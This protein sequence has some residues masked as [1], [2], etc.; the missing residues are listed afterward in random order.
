MLSHQAP[1]KD[2]SIWK[3]L[4]RHSSF[5]IL[6]SACFERCIV[7]ILCVLPSP[8]ILCTYSNSWKIIA[9]KWNATE[10]I[11]F[12]YVMQGKRKH[13]YI[14]IY[15]YIVDEG[16]VFCWFVVHNANHWETTDGCHCMYGINRSIFIWVFKC[17]S[18]CI[19]KKRWSS[20][21]ECIP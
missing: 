12:N 16:I 20:Q 15:I 21:G 4:S 2:A 1:L 3:I 13:I 5:H 7:C 19:W 14:Y 8:T 17:K 18:H 9:W 6:N 10:L 11:Q